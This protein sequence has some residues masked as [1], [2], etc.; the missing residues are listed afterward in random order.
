MLVPPDDGP[1]D[2]A[3]R[4]FVGGVGGAVQVN[5]SGPGPQCAC[6]RPVPAADPISGTGAA[7]SPSRGRPRCGGRSPPA[8]PVPRPPALAPPGPPAERSC[9]RA[10]AGSRWRSRAC[11]RCRAGGRRRSFSRWA[12]PGGSYPASSTTRTSG[13]SCFTWPATNRSTTSRIWTM[14]TVATSAPRSRRTASSTTVQNVR[15]Q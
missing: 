12:M 5:G 9:C 13:A 1:A 11:A 14:V 6:S 8:A 10:S 2:R 3:A 4:L 15:R 7:C